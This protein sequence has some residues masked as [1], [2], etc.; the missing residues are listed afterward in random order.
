MEEEGD[1]VYFEVSSIFLLF[2]G[3]FHTLSCL[4]RALPSYN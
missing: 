4:I 3:F 1:V 2:D